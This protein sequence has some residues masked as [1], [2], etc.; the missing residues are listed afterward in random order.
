MIYL[1]NIKFV[2]LILWPGGAYTDNT[3]ATTVPIT[4]PYYD[5]F[6]E[7]RLYRLIMAK[8]NEPK[9]PNL[10][11]CGS[12]FN[13]SSWF[14]LF[15]TNFLDFSSIIFYFSVSY[16]MNLRNTKTYSTNTLQL[17][18]QRK[19]VNKNCLKLPHFSSILGKIPS[20]FQYFG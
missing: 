20:L 13:T 1:Q 11:F 8:P 2:Q 16:L 9:I 12:N 10:L 19:K 17:K 6:H 18:N 5:S 14:P 7:S 3:Y 4:I 15:L